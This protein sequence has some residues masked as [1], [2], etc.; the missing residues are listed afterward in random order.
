MKRNL[1]LYQ[2]I[3]VCLF[4]G[5]F[6]CSKSVNSIIKLPTQNT[7][8]D[9]TL[10]VVQH[11][12]DSQ[13]VQTVPYPQ[14]PVT[15][16]S[17][18]PDYGDSIIYL[19]PTN[20]PDYIVNTVNNPGAGKFFSWSGGMVIDSLTGAINV[21]KSQTGQKYDIGFVKTGTT[22]TCL[23]SLIIAGAAYMDSV[24]VLSNNEKLALP[25]FNANPYLLSVCTG[26]G[27]GCQFA[28]SNAKVIVNPTTGVIDLQ[29]TLDGTGGILNLGG[30]FGLLPLDGA[31]APATIYYR[32]ND[33]SNNALQHIDVTFMYYTYKSQIGQ[34]LLTNLLTKLTNVLTGN[35]IS[36]S[37][38]PR[39]PVIII[40]RY[41]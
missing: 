24:Y 40:T 30:A 38:N 10:A 17:Y 3:V 21:T 5:V 31:T 1:F 33:N 2:S 15:G 12:T 25:Y 18:A 34:G 35:L 8:H 23:K 39:P 7:T 20:G 13:T 27:P 32:L 16:C 26:N 19:Q 14:A 36:K 37:A 4:V 6:A 29:K 28:S 9:S 11:K 22:D 41:N